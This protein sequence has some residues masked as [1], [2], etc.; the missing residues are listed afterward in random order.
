MSHTRSFCIKLSQH[1]VQSRINTRMETSLV[2]FSVLFFCLILGLTLAQDE[3]PKTVQL[4]TPT[5]PIIGL[6]V[7]TEHAKKNF[8][9]Y[10]FR[11]IPY[12]E[13]PVGKLR[14]KDTVAK[15]PWTEPFKATKYGNHCMQ[16]GYADGFTTY[17]GDE[18]CL[19]LNVATPKLN[20]KRESKDLLPVMV[21]IHGG[22]FVVGESDHYTPDL[23]LERD[24]I[25][26]AMNYRLGQFGFFT[27]GSPLLSG[28]S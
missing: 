18:D 27:L 24:V 23:F 20:E 15:K 17:V 19:F 21:F 2:R 4:D 3:E 9:Y 11:G 16:L 7:M 5:G 22:A 10:S 13:T 28:I 12:A 6:E 25:L 8:P 1:S 14:F 26:V